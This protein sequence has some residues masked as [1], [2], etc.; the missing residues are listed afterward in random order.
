[1]IYATDTSKIDHI[2]AKD[3]DFALIEANYDTDEELDKKIAEYDERGEYT[4]YRRVK[5]THLSQLKAL[6]WLQANN[7]TNYHFIHVHEDKEIKDE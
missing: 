3:Y 7:I 4:Y 2:K 6:N 1:M 5:E